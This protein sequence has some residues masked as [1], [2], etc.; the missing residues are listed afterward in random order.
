MCGI[1]HVMRKDN[2]P[3]FKA[4]VKRYRRQQHRGK[5]GFGYIAIKNNTVVGFKRAATEHEILIHM[6]KE[7]APEIIFHHRNPTSSPNLEETAHPIYV[8]NKGLDHQY[9]FVHNGV[10]RNTKE[11]KIAHEKLGF[12][13]QTELEK[14]YISRLTNNQ[15]KVDTIWNDSESLAIETA[16]VLDGKKRRI[17]SEGPAAVIML[18]MKDSKVINRF[19]YRNN[20]NPLYLHDDKHMTTLTSA[21]VGKEVDH[22]YVNKLSDK[23][24]PETM[25]TMFTPNSWRDVGYN[26]VIP[27]RT[28]NYKEQK[29]EEVKEEVRHLPDPKNRDSGYFSGNDDD[30][31]M[32]EG[33]P[34]RTGRKVGDILREINQLA[35]IDDEIQ[36]LDP[37]FDRYST[38]QLWDKFNEFEIEKAALTGQLK[39]HDEELENGT[40]DFFSEAMYLKRQEIVNSLKE[41]EDEIAGITTEISAR[42]TLEESMGG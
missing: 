12:L 24:V 34:L 41:V 7:D 17:E 1:V 26:T 33:L 29:W 8:E 23:G 39:A 35:G 30:I 40:G 10:S 4:V 32:G 37:Q 36:I 27:K 2:V 42:E 11:L 22:F 16:L 21:T 20:S 31:D 6:A 28:W 18:Q 5:E 15:Y 19:Y 9:L 13:Y 38:I 3:A 25:R 14:S